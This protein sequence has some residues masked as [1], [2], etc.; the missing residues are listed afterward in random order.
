MSLS[1]IGPGSEPDRA[2]IQVNRSPTIGAVAARA[3]NTMVEVIPTSHPR[4]DVLAGGDIGSYA[5]FTVPL[6]V[7]LYG[8]MRIPRSMEDSGAGRPRRLNRFWLYC[9]D[10]SLSSESRGESARC[11]MVLTSDSMR[12]KRAR[13]R[14]SSRSPAKK[15]S[16][17]VMR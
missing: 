12:L 16:R 7:S 2:G 3:A 8:I 17:R 4:D 10:L 15:G 14:G 9:S 5:S 11:C 13:K 1:K 6:D